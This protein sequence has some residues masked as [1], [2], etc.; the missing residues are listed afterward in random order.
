MGHVFNAST[1]EA[2]AGKSLFEAS[3]VYTVS[4]IIARATQR[5]PA[6]KTKQNPE[7]IPESIHLRPFHVRKWLKVP[8][9]NLHQSPNQLQFVV[10]YYSSLNKISL[11]ESS[12]PSTAEL[13]APH[14][15]TVG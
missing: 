8:S 7:E 5:N 9:I 11:L 12:V 1:W 14:S 3:L 2:K 13:I 15:G 4:S 10:F 6:S